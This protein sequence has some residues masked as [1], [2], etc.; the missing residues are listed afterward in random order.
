MFIVVGARETQLS[1]ITSNSRN[2]QLGQQGEIYKQI[3]MF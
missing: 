2:S 1:N 3:I